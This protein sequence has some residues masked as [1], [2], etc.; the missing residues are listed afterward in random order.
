MRRI[1][2]LLAMVVSLVSCVDSTTIKAQT[3]TESALTDRVEVLY[4]HGKQRCI[5]CNAIEELTREV[6]DSLN[7][8]NIVMRVI[9]ISQK[10]NEATADK[11]EVS[12]SSLILDRGGKIVNLTDMG[13]GYAKNRPKEFKKN[14]TEA[15]T[16]I[17]K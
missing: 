9:D 6:V 10:E 2:L 7:N 14:L 4:F 16:Q 8:D 17:M 1:L 5:T 3:Q 11:Y 15:L 12:W 13:F